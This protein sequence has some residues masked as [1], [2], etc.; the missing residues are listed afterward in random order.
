SVRVLL[1][2][3]F[4]WSSLGVY[5]L[6]DGHRKRVLLNRLALVTFEVAVLV[7]E[8]RG[9]AAHSDFCFRVAL[10]VLGEMRGPQYHDTAGGVAAEGG[11]RRVRRKPRRGQ[12]L[13]IRGVTMTHDVVFD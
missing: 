11:H 8:R 1:P 5:R 12:D 7:L 6:G 9:H 4:V 2:H 3:W 13:S 10:D